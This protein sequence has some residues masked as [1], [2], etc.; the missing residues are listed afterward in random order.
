VRRTD[1]SDA[2]LVL[3]RLCEAKGIDTALRTCRSAGVPLVLAGPVG[4]LPDRE[5]LEAALAAPGHPARSHPDVSWF[6]EHVEPHL[7]GVTARWVGSVGGAAK[8]E[9]L[10]TS[11]AALF[12]IRWEEP[13]GTAVCEA[14]AAGTPVVAMARGCLPSLVDDGRTGFLAADEAGFT[15]A[16]GRLDE[17][18]PEACADEAR[19]RFAPAVMAD[20][21]ERL[22]GETLDRARRRSRARLPASRGQRALR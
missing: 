17:I 9:L 2:V 22:Y 6:L 1:R 16:L 20:G 11:R 15:A 13:G 19:R 4:G 7:D 18:D 10:R 8:D 3:A 12:P 14:L 21:Y 5:A